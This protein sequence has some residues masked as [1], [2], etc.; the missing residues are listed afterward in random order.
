[1]YYVIGY[2]EAII[3]FT[4]FIGILFISMKNENRSIYEKLKLGADNL[5]IMQKI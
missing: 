5:K 4:L 1:M 2:P 3:Y